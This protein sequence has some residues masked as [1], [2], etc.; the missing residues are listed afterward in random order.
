MKDKFATE[1][2]DRVLSAV[3]ADSGLD[4]ETLDGIAGSPAIWWEV[5]R[6]IATDRNNG[7]QSWLASSWLLA[8]IKVASPVLAVL[9]IGIGIFIATRPGAGVET[10][11]AVSSNNEMQ[12][13]LVS[14]SDTENTM[15][16]VGDA[17]ETKNR[18]RN[19]TKYAATITG[20]RVTRKGTSLSP[21]KQTVEI[22]SEFLALTYAERPEA[23]HLVRI[24]VPRSMMVTLGLVGSVDRPSNLIDAEVLVGDDG[25]THSIRFIR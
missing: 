1:D 10:N 20:R 3:L 19:V 14:T 25:I 12:P 13:D 17:V 18:H 21:R 9:V 8:W 5:Q 7:L 24:K 2:I 11:L 6:R 15:P 23:G 16:S 4:D 22:K